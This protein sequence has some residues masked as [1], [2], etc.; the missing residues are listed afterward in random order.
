MLSS[1][2][3][4]KK[5][6]DRSEQSILN[7]NAS[8]INKSGKDLDTIGNLIPDQHNASNLSQTCKFPTF[9]IIEEDDPRGK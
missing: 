1:I 9:S 2:K 3:K 5:S 6:L 7:S 4:G 8:S